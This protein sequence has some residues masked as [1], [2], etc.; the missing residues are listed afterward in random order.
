MDGRKRNYRVAAVV[1][2]YILL[3]LEAEF[4]SESVDKIQSATITS[5]LLLGKTTKDDA[6]S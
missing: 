4:V 5:T 3:T 1:A 6:S 2:D